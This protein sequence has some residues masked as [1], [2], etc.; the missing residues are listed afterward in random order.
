MVKGASYYN[1]RRNPKRAKS[2]RDIVLGIMAEHNIISES[3]RLKAQSQSINTVS[4]QR[5]G[6]REYPAFLELVRQQL[7]EDYRLVDLQI[8]RA[9]CRKECRSRWS[10]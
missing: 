5:A 6:Q 9:S 10:M 4:A 7:Q 8:G 2:R 3:E 1:P